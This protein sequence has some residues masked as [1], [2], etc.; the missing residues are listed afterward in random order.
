MKGKVVVVT[1]A[2]SGIGRAVANAFHQQGALVAIGA[3]RLERLEELSNDSGDPSRMLPVKTDVTNADSVQQLVNKAESAFGGGVD[4][5]VNVAGVMYFTLMKNCKT[6]EWNRTVDVNCK[7]VSRIFGN[8]AP[9]Y[10]L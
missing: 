9:F 1:G 4:V 7:G 2:S 5:L 6:D 8:V 10:F 3:R